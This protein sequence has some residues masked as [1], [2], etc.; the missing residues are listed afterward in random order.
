MKLFA[1]ITPFV[2]VATAGVLLLSACSGTTSSA[3]S[4]SG[5]SAPV[6]GTVQ[7]A[8]WAS[9][10][11]VAK[12]DQ[13]N[14]LFEQ[15]YPGV[16]IQSSATDFVS[17]FN[18]LNVEVASRTM[19][20]ITT[21]QTRQLNDYT[22][23]GVLKDLD[24]LIKS[25]QIDVSNIP[26]NVLDYGRG[27]DGKLYMIPFGV[28]WNAIAVNTAMAKQ[29]GIPLLKQGYTW[30]DYAAWLKIAAAKLPNG[31]HVT[32]NQGQNEPTFS[33]YVISNGYK[34]FNSKGKIGFPK[35]VLT[36][37]W[38]M[39]SS[40]QKAGYTSTPQQNADEPPQLEQAQVTLNKV[41]SEQV[42]GNA[43]PGIQAA[44]PAANMTTIAL[45]SGKAGL[46]NMFFVSG[47]S[48]PVN[49]N[50]VPAA[51]AYIDFWT[52]N[53]AAANVFASDNG[54]VAN[55]KQLQ[56]Q[57]ANPV[58]PGVKQVLQQYQYILSQKVASQTMPQGYNAVFEAAFLR[59][60]QD[61]EFGRATVAQAVDAFFNEA[62]ASL[63]NR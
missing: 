63:S 6:A 59:H 3:P 53:D 19:P 42:A 29:Y 20:C 48:I 62:N 7:L 46:G 2:A 50:N 28:A 27:A 9:S 25:G 37:F 55:Q 10:T 57:I 5:S 1:R 52:N 31:V 34:M 24:P 61:V 51:A 21:M 4:A 33:D 36:D 26:K 18:K 23:S 56:A 22:T 40:W 12:Y 8:Y 43:L 41:L 54:A 49:C 13:I 15:K 39:W 47:Y 30:D 17:Y 60:F 58:S 44:N 14:K 35:S 32:N 11:R 16:K 45:P 38:N